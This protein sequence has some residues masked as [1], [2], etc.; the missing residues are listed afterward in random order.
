MLSAPLLFP[1]RPAL[2]LFMFTKWTNQFFLK[3]IDRKRMLVVFVMLHTTTQHPVATTAAI[4]ATNPTAIAATN[5][6]RLRRHKPPLPSP[7]QTAA[8]I[9]ATNRNRHRRH[10]PPQTATAIAATN[11]HRHRRHHNVSCNPGVSLS[12]YFFRYPCV[13]KEHF[14]VH[15]MKFYIWFLLRVVDL[16]K[17]WNTYFAQEDTT[18]SDVQ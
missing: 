16:L 14:S 3:I 13:C 17:D 6:H 1:H 9:A 12:L 15:T 18:L 2:L 10:K 11:R 4:A 5:R 8:A 7:P